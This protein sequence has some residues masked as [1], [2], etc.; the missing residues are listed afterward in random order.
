MCQKISRH[1]LQ[2]SSAFQSRTWFSR[3][4][5]GGQTKQWFWQKEQDLCSGIR[6]M[7]P[8]VCY[9]LT[10]LMPCWHYVRELAETTTNIIFVLYLKYYF[11]YFILFYIVLFRLAINV[12][13][14][15]LPKKPVK[16]KY[17]SL[18]HGCCHGYTGRNMR[19][20]FPDSGRVITG[21]YRVYH[22]I[23]P[24]IPIQDSMLCS[25]VWLHHWY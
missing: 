5:L 21:Q 14:V 1:K 16:Y 24:E 18:D 11:C 10:F 4:T 15:F 9:G 19:D 13:F 22:R 2:N 25:G 12:I 23:D 6:D 8:Q 17:V 7:Q 20:I 3:I